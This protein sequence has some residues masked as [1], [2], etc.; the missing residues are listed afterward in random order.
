MITSQRQLMAAKEKIEMLKKS[1]AMEFKKEVPEILKSAAT[2]QIEELISEVESEIQDYET[3]K[4]NKLSEIQIFSL[5]DLMDAPIKY[6]LAKGMTIEDFAR[7][8]DLHSRQIA[9]YETQHYHN[10]TTDTM[11]KI[12]TCLDIKISG[13]FKV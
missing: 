9:R 7:K 13:A 10:A 6:R 11:L 5:D 8:V 2:G 12:L 4:N 1:L 3:L